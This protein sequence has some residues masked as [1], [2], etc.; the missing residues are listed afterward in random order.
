MEPSYCKLFIYAFFT[1]LC[2]QQ[3][4]D[5][6]RYKLMQCSMH[7]V[8][9]QYC[10]QRRVATCIVLPQSLHVRFWMCCAHRIP[11]KMTGTA[12]TMMHSLSLPYLVYSL[13]LSLSLSCILHRYMYKIDWYYIQQLLTINMQSSKPLLS[14]LYLWWH[15]NLYS[16]Y[17]LASLDFTTSLF[18]SFL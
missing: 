6:P 10:I 14:P 16:K 12:L 17:V 18:L 15:K 8:R 7:H 9:I 5:W 13:S 11:P 4:R 2:S 1:F 3:R